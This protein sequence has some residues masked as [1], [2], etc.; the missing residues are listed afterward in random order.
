MLL[1]N[2]VSIKILS[3][4]CKSNVKNVYDPDTAPISEIEFRPFVNFLRFITDHINSDYQEKLKT[5]YNH[6]T[7]VIRS[8]SQQ[9]LYG[10]NYYKNKINLHQ[11]NEK[12]RIDHQTQVRLSLRKLADYRFISY[13]III[14]FLVKIIFG[15]SSLSNLAIFFLIFTCYILIKSLFM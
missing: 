3:G 1:A 8:V 2:Y 10:P 9:L 11:I 14:F 15:F 6:K 5:L 12:T 13:F 4:V 7:G